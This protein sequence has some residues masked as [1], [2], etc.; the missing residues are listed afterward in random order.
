MQKWPFLTPPG[1]VKNDPFWDLQSSGKPTSTPILT[2]PRGSYSQSTK[3]DTDY[4]IYISIIVSLYRA[5]GPYELVK[6]GAGVGFPAD[7]RS[8]EGGPPGG[9]P[10]GGPPG[11]APRGGP[12]G[13]AP[14]L[15]KK[16]FS[17]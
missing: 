3:R 1:G 17:K 5:V 2:V 16:D 6:M 13:G 7:C 10:L 8:Q 15:S 12:P 9:A 14:L 11:G 4:L